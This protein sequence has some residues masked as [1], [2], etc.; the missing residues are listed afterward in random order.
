MTNK[1]N[2]SYYAFELGREWK[3]SLAE[4]E[5]LFGKDA[6]EKVSE[7]L[8]F[9][10]TGR[11]VRNMFWNMGGVIR[12]FRII[13]PL[14]DLKMFP[15]RVTE[16]LEKTTDEGKISFA[17]GAIGPKIPVFSMGL[18]IKKDLKIKGKSIRF[19][20]KDDR[21]LVSAVVKKE[22][23]AF[24]ER[25]F[26][27]LECAGETVLAATTAIQDIDAYAA[28]DLKKER[29]MEVGML[30]PK[31]AQT[32]VNLALGQSD[33]T[34]KTGLYDPFCGLGTVLIEGANMGITKLLASD[35]SA[36]MV[37]AT[38]VGIER[39]A[40]ARKLQIDAYVMGLDAKNIANF[41]R[42]RDV[43]HIVSEG[44]LGS[45][46]SQETITKEKVAVE[47]RNLVVIYESMFRGLWTAK[48]DG[49]IVMT[50]PCWG[51]KGEFMYFTEFYELVKKMGFEIDP[52][53]GNYKE[54]QPTKYGTLLY[55]RPGQT[56]GRE[57]C[58]IRRKSVR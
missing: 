48:F 9:L 56:V 33:V 27:M 21:N 15:H 39:F 18:R 30:P 10:R 37:S 13:M 28:R 1:D 2:L 58:R 12:A 43:T 11:D 25:E 36:E 19:A 23:L 40:E 6:I 17:L 4:L 16:I 34:P 51:L 53:L 7:K 38:K 54:I 8:V 29:D 24:Y 20:N 47:K 35:I 49:T 26:F 42:L 45:I 41:P 32:M 55:R 3:L 5:A 31:L 14:R 50:I 22:S 46:F 52:L 57:V 44:Y